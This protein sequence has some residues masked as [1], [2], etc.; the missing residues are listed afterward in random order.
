MQDRKSLKHTPLLNHRTHT[1]GP[2]CEL[3]HS[4]TP[5]VIGARPTPKASGAKLKT[6]SNLLQGSNP[7]QVS[8]PK[9]FTSRNSKMQTVA[10]T[11]ERSNTLEG[12]NNLAPVK[13]LVRQPNIIA[14]KRTSLK[15]V[16][17]NTATVGQSGT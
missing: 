6:H 7:Q 2:L 1:E 11:P 17:G 12:P 9:D 5:N 15:N 14:L 10:G 3:E 4:L 16:S 8:R 13:T